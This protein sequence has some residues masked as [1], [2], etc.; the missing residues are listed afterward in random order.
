M[1]VSGQQIVKQEGYAGPPERQHTYPMNETAF[2]LL[3]TDS[4]DVQPLLMRQRDSQQ[5]KASKELRCLSLSS[6]ICLSQRPGGARHCRRAGFSELVDSIS[7]AE[8]RRKH[9]IGIK[10]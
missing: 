8:E 6:P 4:T 7:F 5:R 2:E 9:E 3:H 10:L 1:G